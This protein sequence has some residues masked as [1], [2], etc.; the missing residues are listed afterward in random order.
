[1]FIIKTISNKST[2]IKLFLG[3]SGVIFSLII[4]F[5]YQN[6]LLSAYPEARIDYSEILKSNENSS[7]QL[8]LKIKFRLRNR[9]VLALVFYGRERQFSILYRYLVPNLKVNGGVL[10]KIIF[11]VRTDKKS[12]LDYLDSIMK[13]NRSYFERVFL[14]KQ[15]FVKFYRI[16]KDDDL[17]FKIDDNVVF[18]SNGTFEKMLDEYLNNNGF[19]RSANVVNHPLLSIVHARIRA[20][21]PFVLEQH[22][23]IFRC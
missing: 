10:D 1:M 6:Y 8:S 13:Q 15:N 11:A 5:Q 12:D 23:I 19:I 14:T 21:L 18:I 9:S 4:Y 17:I 3:L 22:S 16:L 2:L 7:S 20:I